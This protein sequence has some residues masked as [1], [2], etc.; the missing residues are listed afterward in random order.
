MP[1]FPTEKRVGTGAS[2]T[3]QESDEGGQIT[4]T[5]T[6]TAENGGGIS[7]ASATSGTVVDAPLARVPLGVVSVNEKTPITI[8]AVT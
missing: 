1:G 2:Y 6:D 4:L 5:V 7:M 8:Q 3:V